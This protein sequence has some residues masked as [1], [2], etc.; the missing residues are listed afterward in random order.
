MIFQSQGYYYGDYKL[1]FYPWAKLLSDHLKEGSLPL[2]ARQIGCGFPLLA[3]GQSAVLYPPHWLL[4]GLL[5]FPFSYHSVFLTH[6][7]MAG[8]FTYLLARKCRLG[9]AGATLAALVFMFGSSYAGLFYGVMSLRTLVWFPLS[10]Y[11]V[12][13]L[14]EKHNKWVVVGLA[15]SW[16]M[17]FLGGYPQ[18]AF[19]SFLASGLHFFLRL[20]EP[21]RRS[22]GEAVKEYLAAVTLGLGL[23]ACQLVPTLELARYSSRAG[24]S[25]EFALQKSFNPLNVLTLFWPGFRHFLGFDFYLG[26]VPLSLAVLAVVKTKDRNSRLFL[27]MGILFVLLALGRHNPLYVLMIQITKAHFFRI[28]SKFIFYASFY[29]ALLAGMGMDQLL[30]KA[31]ENYVYF[32]KTIRRLFFLAIGIYG[33]AFAAVRLFKEPILRFAEFYVREFIYGK[34]G[35]ALSLEDYL[36]RLPD[37]YQ[38]LLA[39]TDLL[40]PYFLSVLFVW[41]VLLLILVSWKQRVF[42]K[43]PLIVAFTGITV[44]DLFFFS[45]Y[46]TGFRGNQ[47]PAH[48]IRAD[49]VARFLASA[50][51]RFRTYEMVTDPVKGAPPWLPNSNML[52]GYS[53]I[54]VYSPLA[55]EAYREYLRDLG[56]VDNASGAYLASKEAVK[57]NLPLLSY[58]NVRYVIARENLDS[59]IDLRRVLSS[60]EGGLLYENAG[61]YPRAFWKGPRASEEGIEWVTESP[62]RLEFRLRASRDET[63]V[64]TETYYPGW[65]AR[66]DGRPVP[67][68]RADKVFRSVQIPKGEHSLIFSFEPKSFMVGCWISLLALLSCLVI[69]VPTIRRILLVSP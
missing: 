49:E 33:S 17:S 53:S 45:F 42:K 26:V 61:Y 29:L 21:R 24:A 65:M 55:M 6:F 62:T 67:I 50:E 25:L 38:E 27:F 2:W 68:H 37:S 23:A 69:S 64:L 32:L 34:P 40:N 58:L 35:H 41:A 51:G 28:P 19:Y 43:W 63:L 14:V 13:R 57:K 15:A 9:V 66:L 46:A 18:M 47:V 7:F 5:P 52:F 10:L 60:P 39:R 20:A 44:M 31:S 48:T 30:S 36:R 12:E 4:L 1:Q 56:A 16:A 8:V 59:I 3:E 54:G 22:K 11:F